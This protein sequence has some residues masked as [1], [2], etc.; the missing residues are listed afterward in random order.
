MANTVLYP[1]DTIGVVGSSANAAMLVTTARKMGLRV[2]AYGADETSEALQLADFKAVGSAKDRDKLQHFAESCAAIVYDSDRVSTDVIKFLAQ[3]TRIPQGSDMLEMMQDRLL[4]RAFFEQLNVNI[5]PYATIIN[6]DD[7]YQSVNSI[8]YPC[9]LKPIQKEWSHGRE[10]V[11]KTQTDIAK[12]AGLLDWGTYILES[13]VAYDREYS[14]LVARDQDGNQQAFP[15][16]EVQSVDD[17]PI[18]TWVPA[19]VDDAVAG[20]IHRVASEVAKNV[21]YVGI[22]EV[23]FYL[24]SSGAIYVKKIVPAPSE[25]GY[26]FEA[27]ATIDEFSEHL[28]AIAGL[29]LAEPQIL[30]PAVTA[31]FTAGQLSAMRTQ[32]Q[33]KA[34]WHFNFYH[35]RHQQDNET[36]G[37]I[38]VQGPSVKPILDQL[39]DTGIWSEKSDN[40]E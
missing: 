19:Q 21:S 34:N 17:R 39:D 23:S 27:A 18:R 33:L 37:H 6:L 31:S 30:T 2:G 3:F 28:R 10:L 29:P 20:E 22:F 4:E 1:G 9:V 5:A 16:T 7:V 35:L 40:A 8:G 32:W 36:M 26:V 15:I 11:I 38:A 24:T 25:T 14:I 13:Q 12:A